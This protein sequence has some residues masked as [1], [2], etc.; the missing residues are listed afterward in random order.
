MRARG[1][2]FT[3]P[4]FTA[5]DSGVIAKNVQ[6][7]FNACGSACSDVSSPAYIDVIAVNAFAGPWNQPGADGCRDGAAFITNEVASLS[8][9]LPVFITNWGRLFTANIQDQVDCM[10]VVGT[11]F[12]AGSPIERVYWFAATDYGGNTSNHLLTNELP[13]GKK[14]GEIWKTACDAL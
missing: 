8:P 10:Q 2:K 13:N 7:F 11:F 12:G 14:L 3:S 9:S 5:G 1:V 6:S 4:L